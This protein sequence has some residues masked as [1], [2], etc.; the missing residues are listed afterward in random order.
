MPPLLAADQRR[1]RPG[2][3]HASGAPL[4]PQE[5][6]GFDRQ[7][8]REIEFLVDHRD[9][10]G[11]GVA[12]LAGTKW[13]AGEFDRSRVGDFG[14]GEDFHQRRFARPIL[15]DQCMHFARPDIERHLLDRHGAAKPLGDLA[16]SKDCG[17]VH[18]RTACSCPDRA[19][20]LRQTMLLSV[21]TASIM[22]RRA[23]WPTV[24]CLQLRIAG[25]D[26]RLR[27]E[28]RSWHGESSNGGIVK[29]AESVGLAPSDSVSSV[30]MVD[31]NP[32]SLVSLRAMLDDIGC[33]LVECSPARKR[34]G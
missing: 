29:I 23:V 24:C 7:M 8:G 1:E 17:I 28:L 22:K 14:P 3:K 10:G 15:A 11:E 16:H 27:A 13:P 20:F 31:D 26:W 30:L 25:C 6:I 21:T 34:C 5:Q 2:E 18:C 19:H 32:A 4:P 9:A 33:R 12:R